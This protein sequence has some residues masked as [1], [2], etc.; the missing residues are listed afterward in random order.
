MKLLRNLILSGLALSAW[1]AQASS[2]LWTWT[3]PTTGATAVAYNVYQANGT[4]GSTGLTYVKI[5]S[6]V[7]T[8]SFTQTAIPTG[9]T[10]NY[11]TAISAVGVEG[12]PSATFQFDTS[13]PGAPGAFKGTYQP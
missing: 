13:A 9:T 7:S 6:A 12:P 3:A 10:C 8:T 2:I 1:Y 5:A 11:V 4:C